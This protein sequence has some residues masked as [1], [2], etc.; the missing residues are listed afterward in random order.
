MY[1][2][3]QALPEPE[4]G[5]VVQIVPEGRAERNAQGFREDLEKMRLR[6]RREKFCHYEEGSL[7]QPPTSL[8]YISEAD[9]FI[10]DIAGVN[11]A[12]REVEV[13]KREQM[14]HNRRVQRAEKEEVRWG[15]IA[16]RFDVEQ[17]RLEQMRENY[18]Y[19]RSNKTSMPYNP[20]NLRYDEGADGDGLKYSDESMHYRGMLRADQL[21][22]RS[23][24]TPYNPITVE[25]IQR[26][27]VPPEPKRP[28]VTQRR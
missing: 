16:E 4:L 12:E 9:R 10:T 8:G 26:V 13:Q 20:I 5:D 2:R 18:S 23:M 25:L 15:Q 7:V 21:Q 6:N 3:Q 1:G 27:T 22:R 14:Y 28:E 11:K 19:A 17:E 24:S